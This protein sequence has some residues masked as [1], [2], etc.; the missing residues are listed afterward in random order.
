M[1][2]LDPAEVIKA[3]AASLGLGPGDL[4]T[5]AEGLSGPALPTV[6]DYVAVAVERCSAKTLPSYGVHFRRLADSVGHKR[7]DEVTVDDIETL[8]NTT[9]ERAAAAKLKRAERAGRPLRSSDPDAYGYGAAENCVRACRFFF[10]VAVKQGLLHRNP[11][12]DVAVPKRPPAP[13]RPLTEDELEEFAFVANTTG[14]DPELDGLLFEFHRKTAARREGGVNLRVCDLDERRCSVTLTEKNSKTRELPLDL[15]LIRRLKTFATTRGAVGPADKVF[16]SRKGQ[17]ITRRRYEGIYDRLD[18]HTEW[19]RILDVGIHWLRHTTLDDV[20]A[21]AGERVAI[22]YAGHADEGEAPRVRWRL[23]PLRT[24]GSCQAMGSTR[25]SYVS[26]RCGW[27][28]II[29]TS[30]GRSGKRCV[31]SP[32]SWDRSPRPSGCGCARL[33]RMPVAGPA[34][35]PS[36]SPS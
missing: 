19:A 29:S 4:R 33:R 20:R 23:Q 31:R 1:N 22:A 14:N 7:L 3:L 15:D 25:T 35:R 21:V 16:R 12:M 5:I 26:V 32:R 17:P 13:E 6:L 9:R 28:W 18:E 24:M 11:A 8:R 34:R 2:N 10:R 30:T 27:S 36:N